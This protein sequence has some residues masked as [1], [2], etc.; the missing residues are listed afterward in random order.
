MDRLFRPEEENLHLD[1]E[2]ISEGDSL[3]IS[4]NLARGKLR[5]SIRVLGSDQRF[6]LLGRLELV[7]GKVEFLD[8]EFELESGSISFESDDS[9]DPVFDLNATTRVQD[10]LILLDIR[11]EVNRVEAF[12]SSDPARDETS[13]IALLTLGVDVDELTEGNAGGIEGSS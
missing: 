5:G 13:I 9:I 7:N 10:I 12:L 1:L 3:E 4:N 6:G 11:S 8:N 2:F